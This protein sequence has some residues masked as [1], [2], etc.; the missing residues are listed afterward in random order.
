MIHRETPL[1]CIN[2]CRCIKSTPQIQCCNQQAIS[3]QLIH[4]QKTRL[5]CLNCRT[6]APKARKQPTSLRWIVA[7]LLHIK[8]TCVFRVHEPPKN[9]KCKNHLGSFQANKFILVC[10]RL[11]LSLPTIL[12]LHNVGPTLIPKLH[13]FTPLKLVTVILHLNH[14]TNFEA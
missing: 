1:R 7:R 11:Q 14:I 4:K 6:D 12:H 13:N 2:C 9:V 8:H 3:T 10:D 5:R